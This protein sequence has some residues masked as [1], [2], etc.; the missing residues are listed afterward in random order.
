MASGI[1]VPPIF[2]MAATA[3]AL[4]GV[5]AASA[6]GAGAGSGAGVFGSGVGSEPADASADSLDA[7]SL[8]SLPSAISSPNVGE[9]SSPDFMAA[10]WSKAAL[11][12]S[13]ALLGFVLQSLGLEIVFLQQHGQL[14]CRRHCA[15]S[16]L[17]PTW[18]TLHLPSWH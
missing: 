15:S 4:G 5:L 10:T 16:L 13:L 9:F 6:A 17:V 12:S 14:L 3:S 11:I 2:S 7:P 8:G 18:Q 1:T